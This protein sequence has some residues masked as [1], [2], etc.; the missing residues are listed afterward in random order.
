MARLALS[1]LDLSPV[2]SGKTARDALLATV[3]LA[4]HVEAL[5]FTRYWVAEH[6]NA[7]SLACTSPEI[8]IG[9]VAAATSSIRVGSGGIMLPNHVPLKVAETF[10]TLAA[11]FPGRIDLGVGRAAGTDPRTARVLRRLKAGEAIPASDDLGADVETL[12]SYLDENDPPRGPFATSIVAAPG[13]LRARPLD[14]CVERRERSL[15]GACRFAVCVRPPLRVG[16][17]GGGRARLPA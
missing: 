11:F 10:R 17:S 16:R 14:P 6:H 4:R 2:S 7:K 1:A 3:D 9:Q 13:G 12:A 8:V 5:G 15:R